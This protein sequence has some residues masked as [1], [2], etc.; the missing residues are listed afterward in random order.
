MEGLARTISSLR[1]TGSYGRIQTKSEVPF[2]YNQIPK[3]R[4]PYA[5]NGFPV[6]TSSPLSCRQFHPILEP[7]QQNIINNDLLKR[8]LTSTL[9]Q[10][11]SRT[12]KQNI[13]ATHTHHSEFG[14]LSNRG[15]AWL[16]KW[17]SHICV[18]ILN[19][20]NV[21]VSASIYRLIHAGWERHTF[22]LLFF[23]LMSNGA[24]PEYGCSKLDRKQKTFLHDY[25]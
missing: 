11:C 18:T 19:F 7:N 10:I 1:R 24:G 21:K 12:N 2:I 8:I 15:L 3:L 13:N 22:F 17:S 6:S 9:L 16:C 23:K 14:Q 20:H 5:W 25:F 4:Q